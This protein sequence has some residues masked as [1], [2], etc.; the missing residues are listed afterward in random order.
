D[1]DPVAVETVSKS[2]A[3]ICTWV[4]CMVKYHEIAKKV[5]P[6]V[7]KV[8]EAQRKLR[9]AQRELD[10]SKAELA[11]KQKILDELTASYDEAMRHKKALEDDAALTQRR[12][13]AATAL[14]DGLAGERERW[15]EQSKTFDQTIAKLI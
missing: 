12:M 3:G 6:M 13:N 5:Q 2:V 8:E 1:F 4:R 11:E 9:A 15:R 10:R 14:I 7:K